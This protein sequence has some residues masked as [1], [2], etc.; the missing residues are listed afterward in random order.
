M[1]TY[2]KKKYVHIL[3]E[4]YESSYALIEVNMNFGNYFKGRKIM[5]NVL[6]GLGNRK[7]ISFHL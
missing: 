3:V 7:Q 6:Q 4:H 5:P 1:P 2:F